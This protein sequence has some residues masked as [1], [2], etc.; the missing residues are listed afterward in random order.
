MRSFLSFTSR[1]VL[2]LIGLPLLIIPT[3]YATYKNLDYLPWGLEKIFG[4]L[5]DGWNGNPFWRMH[6]KLDGSVSRNKGEN[7]W[8]ADY[9]R[10]KGVI[11]QDLGFWGEWW[12]SY[13]W[14]AIRN[15]VWN[16]RNIP[17]VSTS[18]DVKDIIKFRHKGNAHN[19]NRDSKVDLW[20]DF[21]FENSEG[22]FKSHYRHKKISKKYFIHLRWGWKIYPE[23]LSKQ[24]TPMFKDRSVYILQVK[25]IKAL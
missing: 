2:A 11:W 12:Y 3:M 7:G 20:Y 8:W 21:S 4:N 14:V 16:L 5:E 19:T 24:S 23:L 15:P 1:I 6:W 18:V 17:Y 13:H 25:L 9:L 22:E 10:Q